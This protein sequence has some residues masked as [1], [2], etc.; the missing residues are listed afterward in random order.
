MRP[1][2]IKVR[3]PSLDMQARVDVIAELSF[4]HK[5]F[6]LQGAPD[7]VVPAPARLAHGGAHVEFR[8]PALKELRAALRAS[9]RMYD[10]SRK[11][12]P[13]SFSQ[14]YGHIE[15]VQNEFG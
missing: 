2:E 3:D 8:K 1:T 9:I 11:I 5:H 15:S 12:V 10:R 14:L 7:G 6:A 13:L 4:T